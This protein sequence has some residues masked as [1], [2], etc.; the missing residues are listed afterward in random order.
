MNELK[1]MLRRIAAMIMALLMILTL[2]PDL[3]SIKA[4]AATSGTLTGLSDSTI[5]L[6]ATQ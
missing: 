5:G 3:W 6:I 1:R 4:M 2:E